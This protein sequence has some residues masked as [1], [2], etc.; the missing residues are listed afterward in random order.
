MRTPLA[1]GTHRYP[2][3]R[4]LGLHR[5]WAL[6]CRD[7]T[8]LYQVGEVQSCPSLSP[9]QRSGAP[10]GLYGVKPPL[11]ATPLWPFIAK[12]M[13]GVRREAGIDRCCHTQWWSGSRLR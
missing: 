2:E 3:S 8:L 7:S 11:A 4:V 5:M 9:G 1:G 10:K 13:G 12:L 6:I